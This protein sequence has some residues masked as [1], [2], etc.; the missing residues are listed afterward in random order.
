M[1]LDGGKMN[2]ILVSFCIAT[3]QRYEILRELIMEI[4]SVDSERFEVVICDDCSMD[5]SLQKLRKIEDR[6]LKFFVNTMNVGSSQNIYESLEWGVGK[7]LFYVN[8]RDN[9][10]SFKIKKLLSLLD[11]LGEM[12]VA[13]IK[14]INQQYLNAKYQ[15]YAS[16]EE[17]LLEFACRVD[18]PTGYIF[19]RD[20]WKRLKYRKILFEKQYYG[21]Y[22]ITMICAMMALKYSGAYIYGDVCD[23]ERKRID[24]AKVKSGYYLKRKDKRVWYSPGVQWRELLIADRFLRKISVEEALIDKVLYQRYKE[25]LRRVTIQYKETI[26]ESFNTLH[27]N[28]HV[29]HNPVAIHT[30][31]ILN[32]LYMWRNMRSF[33]KYENKRDLITRV[34]QVTRENFHEH[35]RNIYKDLLNG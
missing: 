24:F 18:H 26:S 31:A 16:G 6:R 4:L 1:Y 19:L 22:P 35:I 5:D 3:F 9:V 34:N 25:Y 27:Y 7:Y 29:P 21:D 30:K 8:D 28:L 33:C 2:N 13:F 12:D 32:G 20:V 14:C 15:I 17:A 10:D 23:V 11:E